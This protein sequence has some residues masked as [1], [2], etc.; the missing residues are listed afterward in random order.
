[1]QN[2]KQ[3]HTQTSMHLKRFCAMLNIV[4][5]LLELLAQ[6]LF[7]GQVDSFQLTS[8]LKHLLLC[9]YFVF[10]VPSARYFFTPFFQIPNCYDVVIVFF[11]FYFYIVFVRSCVVDGCIYFWYWSAYAATKIAKYTA[12][13]T[14]FKVT[15]FFYWFFCSL[16]LHGAVT[17]KRVDSLKRMVNHL[18]DEKRCS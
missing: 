12:P 11:L 8:I 18:L 13:N 2:V 14:L 15:W 6:V 9:Y 16:L 10:G 7:V 17:C 1:M 3:T 5:I 4:H